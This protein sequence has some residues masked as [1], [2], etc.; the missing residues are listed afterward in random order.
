MPALAPNDF[1]ID[2]KGDTLRIVSIDE[3]VITVE[4]R[5]SGAQRI[6]GSAEV[7]DKLLSG[8][9][10]PLGAFGPDPANWPGAN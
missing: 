5:R 8:H 9:W 3:S 4:Q 1:F 2:E 10:T 6:L 7:A